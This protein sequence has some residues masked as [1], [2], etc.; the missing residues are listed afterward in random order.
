MIFGSILYNLWGALGSFTIYFIWALQQPLPLPL[1]VVLQSLLAAIVG[2][3]AMYAVRYFAGYIF[4]TPA[5]VK[6]TEMPVKEDEISEN[7]DLD[8]L[9]HSKNVSTVEFQDENSEE[10]AQ[11]VR[12]MLHG[13]EESVAN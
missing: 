5:E 6:Y 12:T 7:L 2:F 9:M 11:V 10:M 3:V 13:N 8:L 4:Y 1:P